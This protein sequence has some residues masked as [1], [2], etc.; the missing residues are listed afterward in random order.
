MELAMEIRGR[1][2]LETEGEQLREIAVAAKSYWGYD[3]ERV[4]SWAALRDFSAEGMRRK[5]C[6]VAEVGSE[7]VGWAAVI[8]RDDVCWLDDLWVLPSA[9]R[10]GIGRR[11]FEVARERGQRSG[12]RRM[13]WEAERNAIGLRRD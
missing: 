10:Q 7:V 6:F 11:L 2:A 13:E 1:A 5:V 4:R 3:V 12:A 8:D 9:M